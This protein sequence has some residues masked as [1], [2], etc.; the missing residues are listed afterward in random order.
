MNA[1]SDWAAV[2]NQSQNS[3]DYPMLCQTTVKQFS[4]TLNCVCVYMCVS[5]C[6]RKTESKTERKT[7][8]ETERDEAM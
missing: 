4:W 1:N 6:Q 3:L 7:E 2:W 8:R 5:V